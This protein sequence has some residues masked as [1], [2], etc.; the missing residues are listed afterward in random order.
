MGNIG[1]SID[2]SVVGSGPY[3]LSWSA[4]DRYIGLGKIAGGGSTAFFDNLQL[5][6]IPEPSSMAILASALIGLLAYAWRKRTYR[7]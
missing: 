2:G 3:S 6:S 5:Q 1:L 7:Y 4:G